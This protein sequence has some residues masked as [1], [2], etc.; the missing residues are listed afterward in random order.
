MKKVT[1]LLAMALMLAGAAFGA[2]CGN[3]DDKPTPPPPLTWENPD[4]SD[5][6]S[7]GTYAMHYQNKPLPTGNTIEYRITEADFSTEQAIVMLI[8]E[9][10]TSQDE[11]TSQGIELLEGPEALRNVDICGAG[12]CPWDGNPYILE[13]G[14][15]NEKFLAIEFDPNTVARPYT[16]LYKVTVGKGRRM[17]DPEV[18]F[19]RVIAE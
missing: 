16:A 9:N 12:S 3:D 7:S 15:N 1:K 17:E 2:A 6:T 13:P 18:V 14:I 10:K 19:M 11:V 5:Y 4:P 8:I